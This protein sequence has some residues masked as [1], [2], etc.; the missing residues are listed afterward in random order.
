M[1]KILLIDGDIPVYRTVFACVDEKYIDKVHH[2]AKRQIEHICAL[3][4]CTHYLAFITHSPSNFRISR[5]TTWPYKG[6]RPND[7]EKPQWYDTVREYY[8]RTLN[9]QKIRGAEADDAL[10]IAAEVLKAEGHT[11]GCATIDK[12]LKQYPW[13]IYVDLNNER[14]HPISPE[15][16]HR[17]L[18]KQVLIGDR[19]DNIPGLSHAARYQTTVEH[20]KPVICLREHLVGESTAEKLLD[21]WDPEDYAK[22]TLE[23]YLDAY[24]GNTPEHPDAIGA[25]VDIPFG[26]YRF[27]ETFDLVYMLREAPKNFKIHFDYTEVPKGGRLVVPNEFEDVR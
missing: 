12:D 5:A 4:G 17:N 11:V 2:T 10:T 3:S 15:Q 21:S 9:F 1:S 22:N 7:K 8:L 19:T 20:T 14:V 13:D 23:M 27:H 24:D 6:D 18:W 16:A 25:C 26:E